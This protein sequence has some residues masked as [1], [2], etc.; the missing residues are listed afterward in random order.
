LVSR[1]CAGNRDSL[2]LAIQ[3][4]HETHLAVSPG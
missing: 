4:A 3:A 2:E 1:F